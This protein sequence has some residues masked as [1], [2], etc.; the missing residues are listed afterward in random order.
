MSSETK[1]TESGD[2]VL[3]RLAESVEKIRAQRA[4]IHQVILIKDPY[5]SPGRPVLIVHPDDWP[6][7]EKAFPK[8]S[9]PEGPL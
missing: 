3:E 4:G 9:K 2:D 8:V 5:V 1:P 7:I 6:E